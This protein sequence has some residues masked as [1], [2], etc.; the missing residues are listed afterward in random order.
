MERN[1]LVFLKLTWGIWQILTWA[2]ESLK[3]VHFNGLLLSKVYVVWAEYV[4]RSYLSWHWRVMQNLKKNWSVAWKTTW[5]ICQISP[6]HS[7]VSELEL[8]MD[9]FVQSR[10]FMRLKFTEELCVMTMKNHTKIEEKLTCRFKI[11][12]KNFTSLDTSTWKSKKFV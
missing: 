6:E 10:K 7:K 4:H 2:L 1:R 11:D 12:M 9:P 3:N 5:R 8:W